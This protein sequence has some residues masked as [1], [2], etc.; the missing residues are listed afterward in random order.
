MGCTLSYFYIMC[1]LTDFTPEQLL[2]ALVGPT[3]LGRIGPDEMQ[4]DIDTNGINA[5]RAIAKSDIERLAIDCE[6]VIG[7]INTG[8]DEGAAQC[9]NLNQGLLYYTLYR[10]KTLDINTRPKSACTED[11]YRLQNKLWQMACKRLKAVGGEGECM[12]GKLEAEITGTDCVM[13]GDAYGVDLVTDI[14]CE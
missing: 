2:A 8:T 3:S 7:D 14:D 12:A 5:Q 6:L 11:D 13:W 1:T 10:Y 9:N 4:A